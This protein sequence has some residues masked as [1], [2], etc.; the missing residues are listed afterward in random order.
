MFSKFSQFVGQSHLHAKRLFTNI[1]FNY[2]RPKKKNTMSTPFEY[3]E[4]KINETAKKDKKKYGYLQF[5]LYGLIFAGCFAGIPLYRV[6]CEHV[7][8]VGNYD[9]KTYEFKNQD[10]TYFAY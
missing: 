1:N 2:I 3:Q 4:Y 6:F 9:K 7:G 10:G 5:G 8:L